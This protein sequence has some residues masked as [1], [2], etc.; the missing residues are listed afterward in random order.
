M[1]LHL[2]KRLKI[3]SE[4][5]SPKIEAL[6]FALYGFSINEAKTV[7]EMRSTPEKETRGILNELGLLIS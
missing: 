4:R 7:L 3:K 5:P 6:V 1:L 2:M